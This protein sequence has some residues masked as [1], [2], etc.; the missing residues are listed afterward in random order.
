M[1]S[2]HNQHSPGSPENP[3]IID[4]GELNND[5]LQAIVEIV[6]RLEAAGLEYV[7]LP[8]PVEGDDEPTH[9]LSDG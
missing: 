9:S 2:D 7:V 1:L 6:F 5:Q 8:A 4:E 3:I